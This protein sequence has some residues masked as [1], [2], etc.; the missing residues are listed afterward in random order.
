[1]QTDVQRYTPNVAAAKDTARML[2]QDL[3][4]LD[5]FEANVRRML[6]SNAP[7]LVSAD[8]LAAT[9]RDLNARVVERSRQL[10]RLLVGP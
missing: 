5:A 8:A 7:M 10:A 9:R 6:D 1:M 2:Q 3:D 4:A